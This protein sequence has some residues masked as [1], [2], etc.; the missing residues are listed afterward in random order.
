MESVAFLSKILI[1]NDWAGPMGPIIGVGRPERIDTI[2]EVVELVVAC[3]GVG[4]T[5][6]S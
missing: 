6:L 2:D 5:Q 1:D 3:V 4:H